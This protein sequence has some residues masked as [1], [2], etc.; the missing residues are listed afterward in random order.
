MARVPGRC[1]EFWSDTLT[2]DLQNIKMTWT[3]Y[4]EIA[5]AV[6]KGSVAQCILRTCGRT[7]F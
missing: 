3:A 2:E 5:D 4:E 6:C 7:K 1:T